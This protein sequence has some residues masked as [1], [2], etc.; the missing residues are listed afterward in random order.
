MIE[1]IAAF[2]ILLIAALLVYFLYERLY[3]REAKE[4]SNL[5]AEALNDLL[6]GRMDKAFSKLRQV[7][8][9]DS[10]NVD[11]YLRLGQILRE[12][13]QPERALQIHRDLTLRTGLSGD[14]KA[15]IL[16]QLARDYQALN[17]NEMAEAALKELRAL[18]P[19]NRWA[20]D[21]HLV[22]L[23][24]QKKWE[25]AFEMATALVKQEGSK[26]KKP[27]AVFK[28]HMGEELLKK[29]EYHKARILF[30]EAIGFDPQYVDAYLSVGDSYYDE[31]RYEDAVTFWGKLIEA[32]PA[33]GHVV[34]GRLKAALFELGRY[35][36]L[37]GVCEQ[38]IQNAPDNIDARLALAE[39]HSK[40]G[41]LTQAAEILSRVVDETPDHERAVVQLIRLYLEKGDRNRL[42]LLFRT[43]ER[44]WEKSG[45]QK[46]E[47][48]SE[49][50]PVTS[51]A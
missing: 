36:D 22:M 47:T 29:R 51:L 27:L 12:Y 23:Q 38:I 41:E 50:V 45:K 39:I 40:K 3:H 18:E 15:S 30:K 35:G 28:Y 26:S 37:A 49:S 43:L 46:Q 25:E 20:M 8:A 42:D 48:K 33:Q 17:N 1:Y 13:S 44:S 31:R 16:E 9:E 4:G 7:V 10:S 2:L 34:I 32:V 5:Y 6:S 11:A 24:K 14:Q 21:T 19:R